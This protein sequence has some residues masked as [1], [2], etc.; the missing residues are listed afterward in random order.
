[1]TLSSTSP[2]AAPATLPLSLRITLGALA[3]LAIICTALAFQAPSARADAFAREIAATTDL[4]AAE[5]ACA[6]PKAAADTRLDVMQRPGPQP[7]RE[8]MRGTVIASA[9]AACT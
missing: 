9:V 2:E 8:D 4:T 3:A 1:M 6:A 7:S 5:I